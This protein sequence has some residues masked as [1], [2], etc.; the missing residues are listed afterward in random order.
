MIISH[1][2]NVIQSTHP[3]KSYA[4]IE[5]VRHREGSTDLVEDED[6]VS[7][8]YSRKSVSD[9][10]AGPALGGLGDNIL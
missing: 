4:T 5:K 10:Y 1:N 6:L 9:D 3:Y 2:E 8:D 7:I